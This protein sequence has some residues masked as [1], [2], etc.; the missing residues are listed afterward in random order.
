MGNYHFNQELNKM[1]N[2]GKLSIQKVEVAESGV[3]DL[4]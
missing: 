4:L 1:I 3:H 2:N